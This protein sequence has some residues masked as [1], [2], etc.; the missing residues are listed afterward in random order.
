MKT[1]NKTSATDL[2]IA[3]GPDND[4]VS[5]QFYNA[6]DLDAVEVIIKVT[7]NSGGAGEKI[8]KKFTLD[9]GDSNNYNVNQ[10]ET[11]DT[12]TVETGGGVEL[13]IVTWN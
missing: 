1:W 2:V 3:T 6:A 7:D 8:I 9:P 10:L 13:N 5:A 11:S 4:R 12:V